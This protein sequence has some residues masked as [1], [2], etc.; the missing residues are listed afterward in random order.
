MEDFTTIEEARRD[1]LECAVY[2]AGNVNSHEAQ[3][4]ALK[5]IVVRYL[6]KQDVDHAAHYADLINDTFVRN[7]MLVSVVAKCVEMNDDD[8]AFQLVDAI[9]DRG[10]TATAREAAAKMLAV[11]GDFAEALSIAEKLEHSSD[12]YAAIAVNQA[13]KGL[14]EDA[15]ETFELIDFDKAKVGALEALAAHHLEKG[16]NEKA[17]GVLEKAFAAAGEIEFP[18]DMIR[19]YFEIGNLFLGADKKDRAIETFA[20][21]SSVIDKLDGVHRDGLYANTAIGFLNAGSL[22]LADR[23]LDEVSDKTEV[24]ACLLGFSQIFLRDEDREESLDALEEAYAILNSQQETE[25]RDSGARNRLFG[26]I[27]VQF[28]RLGKFERAVEI[29]HENVDTVQTNLALTNI[30]QI[31][32]LEGEDELSRQA[33]R[34]IDSDAQRLSAYVALSDVRNQTGH[35]EEAVALL[36]EAAALVETVPQFIVRSE[37]QNEIA[38]RFMLYGEEERAREIASESLRT[39]E[40]IRGDNNRSIALTDLSRIY[41]KYGFELTGEDQE[42]LENLLRRTDL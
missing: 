3:A 36:E 25:I 5:A 41:E 4:E 9:D 17:V 35:R 18:E 19:S 10:I 11:R 38:K 39:I 33:L 31:C 32:V 12:T 22:D 26:N 42:V 16:E 28:A 8:Y 29:A 37:T 30:A 6:E 23:T 27:A 14:E 20:R 24:A 13:K 21:A 7:R 40:E 2:L 1:L 15:A 34:G